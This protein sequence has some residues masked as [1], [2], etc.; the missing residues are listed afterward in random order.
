[1]ILPDYE[2]IESDKALPVKVIHIQIPKEAIISNHET[3]L[4]WHRSIEIIQARQ[5]ALE[6]LVDGHFTTIREGQIYIIN[7]KAFHNVTRILGNAD[8]EAFVLQISYDFLLSHCPEI[9]Q[10]YLMQTGDNEVLES[11]DRLTKAYTQDQKYAHLEIYSVLYHFLYVLIGKCF[12][13]IND[14]AGQKDSRERLINVIDYIEKH[15][16]TIGSIDEISEAFHLS[17]HHLER[18]FKKMT[19][20]TLKSYLTHYRLMMAMAA[21]VT[22]SQS[23]TDIAYDCGFPSQKAF[24][25]A[26]RQV[27]HTSPAQYRIDITK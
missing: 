17:R 26:F 19:G 7:S 16:Q 27:Y 10:G 2:H 11:F 6:L 21:L 4:H 12:V 13:S 25:S 18:S 20:M 15:Y 3:P 23:I 14:A 22:T 1:M 24:Y 8:C 9:E 5:C